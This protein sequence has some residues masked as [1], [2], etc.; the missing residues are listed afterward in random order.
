MEIFALTLI[1]FGF[2]VTVIALVSLRDRQVEPAL[3]AIK[4]LSRFIV[5]LKSD[6]T[7]NQAP[8]DE[9]YLNPPPNQDSPI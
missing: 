7:L 6:R 5:P 9:P 4:I 1:V 8:S 3:L 2:F